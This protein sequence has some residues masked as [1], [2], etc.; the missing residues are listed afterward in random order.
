MGKRRSKT[1]LV[2][3]VLTVIAIVAVI[4]VY[5]AVLGPTSH[6]A[7]PKVSSEEYWPISEG[8]SWE[9]S[10]N[11]TSATG[12]HSAKALSRV[13]GKEIIGGKQYFKELTVFSGIPGQE[14]ETWYYRTTREGIYNVRGKYKD[15]PEYLDPPFPLTVGST[16][17]GNQP[18]RRVEFRVDAVETAELYS[19]RYEKCLKV[20]FRGTVGSSPIEGFYYRAP[21][22]GMV[23]EVW[24]RDLTTFEV[25]LD[26]YKK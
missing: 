13:E 9:Y 10:F 5:L 20:S 14:P 25:I 23:K 6:K 8:A 26:R 18:E 17:S 21:N 15:R 22:V 16:W 1:V 7:E 11:Y 2:V 19:Q 12:V 4:V 24:K 3:A